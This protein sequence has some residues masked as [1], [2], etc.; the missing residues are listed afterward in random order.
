MELSRLEAASPWLQAH[1][2]INTE[3]H[4]YVGGFVG[5]AASQAAWLRPKI[6]EWVAGVAAL[7]KAAA[8]L[9]WQS[10]PVKTAL[11]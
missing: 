2:L 5:T 4:R 11:K 3:G 10:S 8:H 9:L 1:G 6:N 7:A